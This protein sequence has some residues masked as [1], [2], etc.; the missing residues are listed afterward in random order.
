MIKQVWVTCVGQGTE[1]LGLSSQLPAVPE[2]L[3]ERERGTVHSFSLA[4]QV[5]L[6]SRDECLGRENAFPHGAVQ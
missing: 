2:P 4:S 6:R 3:A 1:V 5:G